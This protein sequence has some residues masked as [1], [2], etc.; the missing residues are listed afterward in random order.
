V[1]LNVIKASDRD[2]TLSRHP[3]SL[4]CDKEVFI[5]SKHPKHWMFDAFQ[6][7]TGWLETPNRPGVPLKSTASQKAKTAVEFPAVLT[8][9]DFRVRSR[10]FQPFFGR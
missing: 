1:E 4:H 10:L 2:N 8:S 7:G 6:P 5:E 9:G 3:L